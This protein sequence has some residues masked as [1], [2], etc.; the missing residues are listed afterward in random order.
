MFPASRPPGLVRLVSAQWPR[1]HGGRSVA[2]GGAGR[3]GRRE[4]GEMSPGTRLQ[5]RRTDGDRGTG[6]WA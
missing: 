3:Q 4:V 1:R 6:R 2:R 5:G